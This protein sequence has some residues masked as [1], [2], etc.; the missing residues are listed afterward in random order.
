MCDPVNVFNMSF[1]KASVQQWLRALVELHFARDEWLPSA[2]ELASVP[3]EFA[4]LENMATAKGCTWK[5]AC[6][7]LSRTSPTMEQANVRGENVAFTVFLSILRSLFTKAIN[8]YVTDIWANG[9][10]GNFC[11]QCVGAMNT[12]ER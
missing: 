7:L 9:V 10:T 1:R 3:P 12:H 2:W 4:L 11:S 8:K 5:E 6:S